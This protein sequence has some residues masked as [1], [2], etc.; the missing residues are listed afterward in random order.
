MRNN[1][2]KAL[3]VLAVAGL[4]APALAEVYKWKD[5]QGNVHFSD[6]PPPT[7]EGKAAVTQ[8]KPASGRT[9]PV[10]QQPAA[11]EPG[12]GAENMTKQAAANGPA[13]DKDLEAKR[14][15]AEAAQTK[16]RADEEAKIKQQN[17]ATSK[18]WLAKLE[19][20][21][22]VIKP[23]ANGAPEFISDENRPAEIAN[24]RREVAKY[25]K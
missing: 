5:A 21:G 4:A 15:A 7:T 2:C 23:G 3:M 1:L 19:D 6:Q 17:C 10:G 14:K 11:T 13:G 22:R 18:A 8:I 9:M 12:K 20:Q 24:A 16:A 25:C